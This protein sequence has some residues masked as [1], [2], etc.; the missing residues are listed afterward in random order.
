MRLD[1][2][3][4]GGS[5]SYGIFIIIFVVFFFSFMKIVTFSQINSFTKQ[6]NKFFILYIIDF[7]ELQDGTIKDNGLMDGSK[8][9]LIPN[10]ETGLLVSFLNLFV[11]T[12]T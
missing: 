8:I 10:V 11:F 3:L 9:I 12:V 7:R 6:R 1:K 5:T 2:I 4:K